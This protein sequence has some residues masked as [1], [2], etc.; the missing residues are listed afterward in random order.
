MK[1][2]NLVQEHAKT[3]EPSLLSKTVKTIIHSGLTLGLIVS[4]ATFA[5]EA[6][7]AQ[8]DA[9][10]DDSEIVEKI[11]VT[12]VRAS[13]RSAI[14]RK[15]LASTMS[16][17]IVAEDIGDFP[18]KNIAEALSRVTGIQ[19]DRE[20]GEGGGVSIRGVEPELT[21]VEINGISSV[22]VRSTSNS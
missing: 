20:F 7:T 12:G 19:L 11:V 13:Q 5:Q 9:K 17:S 2:L 6:E 14:D 8:E 10:K 21:R 1:T 16:D 3:F 18:D 15:K 22:T 4:S